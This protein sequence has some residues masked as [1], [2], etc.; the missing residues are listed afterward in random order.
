MRAERGLNLPLQIERVERALSIPPLGRPQMVALA[1]LGVGVALL[2]LMGMSDTFYVYREDVRVQGVKYTSVEEVYKVSGVEGCHAFY[3][4]PTEV[5]SRVE[6]LPFVRRA[7]VR[8]MVPARVTILVEERVPVLVWQRADGV[9]WVDK[10]GQVLPPKGEIRG[11]LRVVDPQGLAA[12]SPEGSPEREMFDTYLLQTLRDIHEIF[13]SVNTVLYDRSAGLRLVV[14]TSAGDMQVY[15][16]GYI[17][18]E[19]RLE[20]LP[21]VLREM[22]RQGMWYRFIDLSNPDQIVLEP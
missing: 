12:V 16:G 2:V 9:F 6:Q 22:R 18:L 7:K 20:Y 10:E 14:R 8:V 1:L 11:L 15:L 19:R 21:T 13:P 5:A 4:R 3:V 17:G